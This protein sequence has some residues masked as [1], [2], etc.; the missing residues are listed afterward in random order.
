[1]DSSKV[2]GNHIDKCEYEKKTWK[3]TEEYEVH[4]RSWIKSWK[5]CA[6]LVFPFAPPVWHTHRLVRAEGVGE[7]GQV[8][9]Q[10]AVHALPDLPDRLYLHL[11]Q[12][13]RVLK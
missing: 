4:F 12:D 9:G 6:A 8:G 10:V 5:V 3:A 11:Q 1:M 7:R 13:N 2:K